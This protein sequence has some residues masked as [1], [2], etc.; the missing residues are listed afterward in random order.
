[1]SPKHQIKESF[2]FPSLFQEHEIGQHRIFGSRVSDFIMDFGPKHDFDC[3]PFFGQSVDKLPSLVSPKDGPLSPKWPQSSFDFDNL[4]PN[5][6]GMAY[7]YMLYKHRV[8]PKPQKP[9]WSGVRISLENV[10][11]AKQTSAKPNIKK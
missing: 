4:N 6:F 11:R 9:S 10:C 1:M 2:H 3:V 8:L 5:I 7:P